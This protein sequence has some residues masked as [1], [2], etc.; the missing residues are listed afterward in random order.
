MTVPLDPITM[1]TQNSAD[2][3]ESLPAS[4]A[5]SSP[6]A[7]THTPRSTRTLRSPG[8][9]ALRRSPRYSPYHVAES[10]GNSTNLP[11]VVTRR[12]VFSLQPST[13]TQSR[14][15]RSPGQTRLS[16]RSPLKT[17][18]PRNEIWQH[19][20][21]EREG[22]K[23]HGRCKYCG[24][25][26]KN[27]KPRGDLLR[28]LT[29]TNANQCQNVPRGVQMSLR[30]GLTPEPVADPDVTPQPTQSNYS[31]D[32]FEMALERVLFVCALPFVLIE[33]PVFRTFLAM[34]APTM[35]LPSRRK[36]SSVLLKRVRNELRVEVN[37]LISRQGY[38]SLV[39][40]GW[41][42]TNSSSII[43]FMVV[44]PGM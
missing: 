33:A 16:R 12:V 41:S 35:K 39:T 26:V 13:P 36:L 5:S 30:L 6:L 31:Q 23:K 40:D 29:G 28:H 25:L 14:Q 42:D 44:A 19:F 7:A 11:P 37:K 3:G 15:P 38:V 10:S 2:C 18:R 22:S 20:D 34:V 1:S 32:A 24:V 21:I 4:R 43:N 9:S 27:G 17:G 8:G